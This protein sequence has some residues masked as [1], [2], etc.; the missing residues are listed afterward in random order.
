MVIIQNLE[1]Q[2]NGE[3]LD[4]VIESNINEPITSLLLW[5]TEGFKNYGEAYDLRYKLNGTS[6]NTITV[7]TDELEIE[8]FEDLIFIEVL[9]SDESPGLEFL[10]PALGIAYNLNPYRICLLEQIFKQESSN[11]SCNTCPPIVTD[12][13]LGLSL[14]IDSIE[15]AIDLGYYTQAIDTLNKV[16]KLCDI[17]KCKGCLKVKCKTC[18]SSTSNN[19]AGSGNGNLISKGGDEKK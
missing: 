9:D 8:R 16:K 2:N 1:I 6:Y 12:N 17:R 15:D 10:N 19:G 18:G 11:Q 13:I 7:T 14:L 3:Q 4:I 5:T